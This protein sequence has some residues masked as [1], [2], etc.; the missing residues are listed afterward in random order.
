MNLFAGNRN[1]WTFSVAGM[2]IFSIPF[3]YLGIA[4]NDILW[5]LFLILNYQF[6]IHTELIKTLGPFE[7]IINTPSLHRVHHATEDIY[8]DKNFGG[9]TLLF[10]YIFGT[11]Q[12]ELPDVKPSYGLRGEPEHDS[13]LKLVFYGWIKTFHDFVHIRGMKNKLRTLVS[14]KLASEEEIVLPEQKALQ[15]RPGA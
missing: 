14:M 7:K 9:I 15:Q 10:D 3:V 4:W 6:F 1:G 12:R 11:L 13:I 2:W 8:L 5:S